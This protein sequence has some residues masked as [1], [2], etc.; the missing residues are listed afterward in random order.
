MIIFSLNW[1]LYKNKGKKKIGQK[2]RNAFIRRKFKIKRQTNIHKKTCIGQAKDK[3]LTKMKIY[4][5]FS[6]SF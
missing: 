5:S 2:L 6:N 1:P 3:K 4:V